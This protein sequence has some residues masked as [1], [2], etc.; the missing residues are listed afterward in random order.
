[1]KKKVGKLAFAFNNLPLSERLISR[2]V[3]FGKKR[4]SLK[5]SIG[6]LPQ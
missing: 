4:K 3:H 5:G 2:T 1:M 6:N